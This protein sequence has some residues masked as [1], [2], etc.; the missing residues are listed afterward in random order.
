MAFHDDIAAHAEQQKGKLPHVRGEEA[1]KQALVIPLLRI[2]G[3]D[4]YDPREIQPE[5][6]ADFAIKRSGQL[7][8]VD[9][10]I[11]SAGQPIIFVECKAHDQVL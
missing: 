6:T 9:Y 3:Y 2:L 5:Y 8:K 11:L 1:T 4:V 7:E 10:A